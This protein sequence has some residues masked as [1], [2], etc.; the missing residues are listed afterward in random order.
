MISKFESELIGMHIGDGT[1]Y[2]TNSNSLVWEI[3]GG[4]DEKEYYNKFVKSLLFRIFSIKI[5]P[6]IRSGGA[7]GSYG[8][9]TSKK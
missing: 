9:Q 4:L 2:K 5:N 1:L 3:R 8:I 6:K 7:K